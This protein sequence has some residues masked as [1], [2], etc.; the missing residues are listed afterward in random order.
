MNHHLKKI[1]VLLFAML[2]ACAALPK[3]VMAAKTKKIYYSDFTMTKASMKKP[4]NLKKGTTTVKM[5]D[6]K[7]VYGSYHG[8]AKFKAAKTKTYTFTFSNLKNEKHP[9]SSG[10]VQIFVTDKQGKKWVTWKKV[11]SQGGKVTN[12]N[13]GESKSKNSGSKKNAYLTSRYAKLKIKKGDT[14]YLFFSFINGSKLD[15][16]IK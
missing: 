7:D 12:L 3:P 13:V 16:K 10:Y 2:L 15:V 5:S 14:V 1:T 6:G 11:S 8:Y 4:A 9:G